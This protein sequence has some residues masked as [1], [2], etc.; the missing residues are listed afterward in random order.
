MKNK[1]SVEF[2]PIK[3]ADC[4]VKRNWHFFWQRQKCIF[5]FRTKQKQTEPKNIR[6]KMA[7]GEENLSRSGT[8]YILL[9]NNIGKRYLKQFWFKKFISGNNES[10]DFE[11]KSGTFYEKAPDDKQPNNKSIIGLI[12]LEKS[13]NE[14]YSLDVQMTEVMELNYKEIK[15]LLAVSSNNERLKTVLNHMQLRRACKAE[16]GDVVLVKPH[17]QDK[18]QDMKYGII[19]NIAPFMNGSGTYF[20]VTFKVGRAICFVL[21]NH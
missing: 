4:R 16:L 2:Y 18:D 3:S 13:D 20:Y 17:V 14:V 19:K 5:L 11:A 7:N 9:S 10:R 8:Y 12:S 6:L 1:L 15:L 21:K